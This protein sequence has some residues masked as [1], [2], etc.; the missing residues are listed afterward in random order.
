[1]V[2]A[3]DYLFIHQTFDGAR[4]EL[5]GKWMAFHKSHKLPRA[6]IVRSI[7]I[8]CVCVC[9]CVLFYTRKPDTQVINFEYLIAFYIICKHSHGKAYT[10]V[11]AV[12]VN[13]FEWLAGLFVCSHPRSV[14]A[15][16]TCCLMRLQT[17][18]LR[19]G[20]IWW[21]GFSLCPVGPYGKTKHFL[22]SCMY[23]MRVTAWTVLA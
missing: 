2:V 17:A 6:H 16:Y 20:F 5:G 12:G 15:R 13:G 21:S 11:H 8:V 18:A 19:C 22:N 3:R 10:T 1:M 4:A 14:C 7:I 9:V 23:Y